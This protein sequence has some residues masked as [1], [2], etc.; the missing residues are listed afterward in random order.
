MLPREMDDIFGMAGFTI[1]KG[2]CRTVVRSGQSGCERQ[3]SQKLFLSLGKNLS[4][5]FARHR[6]RCVVE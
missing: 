3:Y 5:I 1:E 2:E 4:D 6:H